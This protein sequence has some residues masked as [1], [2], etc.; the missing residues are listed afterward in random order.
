MPYSGAVSACGKAGNMTR[1]GTGCQQRFV[2]T[3]RIGVASRLVLR[4]VSDVG[5]LR[6]CHRRV[7]FAVNASLQYAAFGAW[8]GLRSLVPAG[9]SAS[10]WLLA[11]KE[12]YLCSQESGNTVAVAICL[13]CQGL[14]W[15]L[16]PRNVPW[17]LPIVG[18]VL[19]S[20][21]PGRPKC[22]R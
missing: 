6:T 11:V 21:Y 14:P 1:P 7:S 16:S 22:S 2:T 4:A 18:G 17:S 9:T 3:W 19:G 12:G 10:W 5:Q 20:L 13:L 15:L 8:L